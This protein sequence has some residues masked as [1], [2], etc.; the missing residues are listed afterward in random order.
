MYVTFYFIDVFLPESYKTPKRG[1]TLKRKALGVR[2]TDRGLRDTQLTW[3]T[4]E[5]IV[6]GVP[7]T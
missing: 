6:F 5:S 4:D 1:E 7:K 3:S 2:G